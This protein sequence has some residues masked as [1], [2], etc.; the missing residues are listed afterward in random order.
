MTTARRQRASRQLFGRFIALSL[1]IAAIAAASSC[2]PKQQTPETTIQKVVYTVR[3]RV[4]A[5]PDP[6]RP[7]SEFFVHHEPILAFREWLP[8]GPLGMN[9]MTMPFPLVEGVSL[10]GVAVGDPVEVTFEVEYDLAASP[11]SSQIQGFHATA[12]TPLPPETPLALKQT[13]EPAA[14]E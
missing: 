10:E 1:A 6:N 8:D 12:V 14:P 13:D 5:L 7:A 3:G 11:P 4:A 9:E 2:S